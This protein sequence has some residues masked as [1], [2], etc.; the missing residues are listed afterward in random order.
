MVV[1]LLVLDEEENEKH[2]DEP[3]D[4]PPPSYFIPGS[5]AAS[6]ES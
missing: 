6:G 3:V 5:T 1:V 2:R 4:L